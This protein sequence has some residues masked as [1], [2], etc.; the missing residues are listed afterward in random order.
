MSEAWR[1]IPGHEGR[2]QASSLGRVRSVKSGR[3]LRL[4]VT[5]QGYRKV[6]LGAACRDQRV[7]RL[8]LAAFVGSPLP[9]EEACHSDGNRANNHLS[10]LRWDTRAGNHADKVK[11]GTTARGERNHLAKLTADDVREIRRR[12][13]GGDLGYEIARDFNVTAANI[14]SIR[15]N[16]TWSHI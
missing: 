6:S 15:K 14:S 10:N 1:D 3:I 7:H 16:K 2:Y 4:G 12:L 5:P 9:C 11:H 8:V 13:A